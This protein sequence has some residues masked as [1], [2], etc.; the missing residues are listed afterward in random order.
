MFSAPISPA[1]SSF[2]F[3][4]LSRGPASRSPTHS[5][6]H[7]SAESPS[8]SFTMSPL[9]T[10]PDLSAAPHAH[11]HAH[12]TVSPGRTRAHRC[13]SDAAR[14]DNGSSTVT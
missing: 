2:T 13:M 11:A 3:T 14:H 6:E 12:K 9:A 7:P 1:R 8:T 5:A 4:S 10:R